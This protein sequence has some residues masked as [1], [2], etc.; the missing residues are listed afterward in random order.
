[1]CSMWNCWQVRS[2]SILCDRIMYSKPSNDLEIWRRSWQAVS[3]RWPPM[4]H[5]YRHKSEIRISKTV[6]QSWR[7]LWEMWTR[8]WMS[9]RPLCNYMVRK[10]P[11]TRKGV[12]CQGCWASFVAVRNGW[13]QQECA[14]LR[15]NVRSETC[16]LQVTYRMFGTEEAY[17]EYIEARHASSSVADVWVNLLNWS[18]WPCRC[19]SDE[20][21]FIMV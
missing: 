10:D 13:L 4:K 11:R 7:D 9:Q 14:R 1:M 2:I 20:K 6:K 5:Y 8:L 18:I 19:N 17:H 21:L 3:S 15:K 12:K 16:Y